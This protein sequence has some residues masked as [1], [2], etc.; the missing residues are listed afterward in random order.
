MERNST[1][2][3][4]LGDIIRY[5]PDDVIGIVCDQRDDIRHEVRWFD[6]DV[7][8][9]DTWSDSEAYEKVS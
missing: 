2:T 6:G 4:E 8:F 3:L 9:E 1:I 5:I 7:T